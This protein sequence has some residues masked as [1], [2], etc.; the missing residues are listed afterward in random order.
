MDLV[1]GTVEEA[2]VDKH[3]AL[4]GRLDAGLEVDRGTALLVHDPD[5]Q[6]VA[7]QLQH[8]FDAAEQLVG[9]RG[10]FRAVHLRLNDVHRTGAAVLA[11]VVAVEA[12]GRGEAGDQ[13]VEN[14][15][16]HFVAVFVEDRIDGH[17][18]THVAHEQ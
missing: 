17:Q 5:F 11:A 18:V 15:F 14:A 3:H 6:R 16:R 12:V 2:G 8:V 9:E 1:A 10:F 4:A 7:R 13:A